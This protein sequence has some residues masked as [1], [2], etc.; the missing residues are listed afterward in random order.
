MDKE[1]N[2][3]SQ[4]DDIIEFTNELDEEALN[5]II[6]LYDK[7]FRILASKES[8]DNEKGCNHMTNDDKL[9][10]IMRMIAQNRDEMR[11]E[12]KN[13]NNK[14]DAVS[15]RVQYLEQDVGMLEEQLVAVKKR[16]RN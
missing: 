7:T 6:G 10:L 2:K 8:D 3:A 16:I 9:N 11:S 14:I 13:I 4:D 15:K 1:Q 5:V 12:F